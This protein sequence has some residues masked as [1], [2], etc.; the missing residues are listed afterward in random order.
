MAAGSRV[1][2]ALNDLFAGTGREREKMELFSL[3]CDIAEAVARGEVTLE[4]V[5]GDVRKLAEVVAALRQSAGLASNVDEIAERLMGVL[6]AES[7]ARSFASLRAKYSALARGAPERR[8]A[9][10]ERVGLL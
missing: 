3:L 1:L 5:A 6:A 8:R 7:A 2:D 4:E 10:E 9:R